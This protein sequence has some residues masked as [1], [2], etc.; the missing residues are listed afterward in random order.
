MACSRLRC[1]F[2]IGNCGAR[3]GSCPV[4]VPMSDGLRSR[5]SPGQNGQLTPNDRFPYCDTR[6]FCLTRAT[7]NT[8]LP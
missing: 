5:P 6:A 1:C 4:L 3:T 7:R 8:I 2:C